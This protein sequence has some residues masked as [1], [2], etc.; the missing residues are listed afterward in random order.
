MGKSTAMSALVTSYRCKFSLV[1][2]FIGSASCNP[3]L[4][5]QLEMWFD[6]RFFFNSWDIVLMK[7]L[8]AQQ[9]KLKAAGHSR[10]VLIIVD[11]VV[12]GGKECDQ[13]SH[14]CQRGRHFDISVM[15][16]CV[17]YTNVPKPARRSLDTVLLFSLPM[18]G[19]LQIL[20][21][22]F[23]TR[24]DMA[25]FALNN[26]KDHECLV[27]ETLNKS[28][29]LYLWTAPLTTLASLETLGGS[30]RNLLKTEVSRETP[31]V[32]S[33]Q[34]RQSRTSLREGSK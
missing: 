5:R 31:L 16:C 25:R 2:S 1:I 10:H 13:L 8:L 28:Q 17:S 26:L 11:D 33:E 23:T 32:D 19:D 20:T 9:E 15:M 7:R 14:L 3:V 30:C 24:A 27:L 4:Q 12:L 21:W 29:C 6:D 18:Q 22:E 34:S